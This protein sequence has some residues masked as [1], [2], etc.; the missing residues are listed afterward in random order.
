MMSVEAGDVLGPSRAQDEQSYA[1]R[2]WM[3]GQA[4]RGAGRVGKD[5]SQACELTAH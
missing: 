2:K 4:D 1:D 5:P 3:P